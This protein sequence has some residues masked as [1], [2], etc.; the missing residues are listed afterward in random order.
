MKTSCNARL[1]TEAPWPVTLEPEH[2]VPTD[3][4]APAVNPTAETSTAASVHTTPVARMRFFRS[5]LVL[6]LYS[7]GAIPDNTPLTCEE[8]TRASR[9]FR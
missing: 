2:C 8:Y 6:P 5:I 7:R 4:S 3:A 9:Y 1:S